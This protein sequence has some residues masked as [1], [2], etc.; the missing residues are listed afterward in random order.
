M[1]VLGTEL[2]YKRRSTITDPG[3][4]PRCYHLHHW[5]F[6]V[7]ACV[8][9]SEL[10]DPVYKVTCSP[11]LHL[12]ASSNQECNETDSEHQAKRSTV[13]IFLSVRVKVWC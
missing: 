4:S 7:W 11:K 13:S 8:L 2:P 3:S 6:L 10:R 12:P 1:S 5:D 9:E